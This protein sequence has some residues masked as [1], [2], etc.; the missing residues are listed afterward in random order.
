MKPLAQNRAM[1]KPILVCCRA[2]AERSV[3]GAQSASISDWSAPRLQRFLWHAPGSGDHLPTRFYTR[4]VEPEPPAG[5]Q[6][7]RLSVWSGLASGDYQRLRFDW[8]PR[9]E[10]LLCF[11]AFHTHDAGQYGGLVQPPKTARTPI[12]DIRA[13][14]NQA[15][16]NMFAGHSEPDI[17]HWCS[18]TADLTATQPDMLPDDWGLGWSPLSPWSQWSLWRGPARLVD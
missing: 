14:Q 1:T 16:Q 5:Q 7:E 15:Q 9:S 13:Q 4:V 12:A 2:A 3:S 8:R 18:Y 11:D 10:H 17:W 6:P